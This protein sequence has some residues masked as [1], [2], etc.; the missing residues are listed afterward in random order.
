MPHE[1]HETLPT[2]K[3][4][5]CSA[6]CRSNRALSLALGRVR[7][8]TEVREFWRDTEL[9]EFWRD[10]ELRELF[11]R[12]AVGSWSSCRAEAAATAA[13]PGGDVDRITPAGDSDLGDLCGTGGS[14]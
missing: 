12:G 3:A 14:Q 7:R 2:F 11:R 9:R 8:G 6:R 13:H 5:L 1:T 4:V 10:T